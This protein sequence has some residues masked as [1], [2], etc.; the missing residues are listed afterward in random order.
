MLGSLDCSHFVW[1]SCPVAYHGQYQ[2]KEGKPTLV[3][4]VMVDHTLYTWHAV[5]GY[6]GTLNDVTIWDNS[7]LLQAMCDGSFDK[8]DFPF[9]VGGKQFP[10]LFLLVD[11]IYPPL[12]R[13]VK[14]ISVPI[15]D[16]EVLFSM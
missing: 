13:F 16:T 9:T 3:V 11:G 2:G 8:I 1:G 4:E 10:K 7:L 5:F 15:G 14:H 6:C 12:S